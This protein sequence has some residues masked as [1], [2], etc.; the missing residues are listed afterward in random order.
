[1]IVIDGVTYNVGILTPIARK[2]EFLDKYA[3]RT[4]DGKLHRELIGVYFNYEMRFD[5]EVGSAAEYAALYL[6]ITEPVP[7]HTVT[8]WDSLGPYTFTAYISG[9]TDELN[10]IRGAEVFW[11]N[12]VVHFIAESPARTP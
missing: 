1:M 6:K 2:A 11:T 7:F 3:E 12:L 5:P 10:R 4:E 9:V 8:L